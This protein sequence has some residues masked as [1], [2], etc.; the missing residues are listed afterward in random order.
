MSLVTLL[1]LL[2]LV[3]TLVCHLLLNVAPTSYASPLATGIC[4]R[5]DKYLI[6]YLLEPRSFWVEF[7]R[8]NKLQ[9]EIAEPHAQ[10]YKMK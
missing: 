2:L 7:R 8:F 1:L 4:L 6:G 10:T 9:K 3:S 5:G